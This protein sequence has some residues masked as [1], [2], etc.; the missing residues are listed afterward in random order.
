MT[1]YFY[2]NNETQWDNRSF[3]LNK[4]SVIIYNNKVTSHI[5]KSKKKF[6]A[7]ASKKNFKLMRFAKLK[8]LSSLTCRQKP[9]NLPKSERSIVR[10]AFNLT[11]HI[12]VTNQ[13]TN[14]FPFLKYFFS[15]IYKKNIIFIV[16]IY[17]F[18]Y[19]N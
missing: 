9:D 4:K 11:N 12:P 14:P 17:N 13:G 18:Q 3:F 1:L 10:S 8:K 5:V 2:S 16:S 15:T 19:L 6:S 7:T